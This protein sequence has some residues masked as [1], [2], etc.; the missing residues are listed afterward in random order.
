MPGK[1]S[2]HGT[3][4]SRKMVLSASWKGPTSESE[5]RV[6]GEGVSTGPREPG[7]PGSECQSYR[8]CDLGLAAMFKN[9]PSI[10]QRMRIIPHMHEHEVQS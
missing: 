4:Y 9:T 2:Y 3:Q 7:P 6:R 8:P 10:I 1:E 5:G